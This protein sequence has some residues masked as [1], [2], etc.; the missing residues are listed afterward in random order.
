MQC[1]L[2]KNMVVKNPTRWA[3]DPSYKWSYGAPI[4]R[5]KTPL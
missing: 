5:E 2:R 1:E 4:S 3:P